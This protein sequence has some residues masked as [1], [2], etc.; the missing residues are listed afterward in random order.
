[1]IPGARELFVLDPSVAHLNHGSFGAVPTV[2]RDA[3]RRLLDEFDSNPMLMITGD[4]REREAASRA[5]LAHFLGAEEESCA[6][7]GN[8][9]L[10]ASIVL[11]SI[12]LREGDEIVITDHSYNA[13]TLAVQDLHRRR[14]VRVIVAPV[15]LGSSDAQTVDAI[16]AHVGERTRLVIV[17]EISSATAQRHP[18]AAIADAL[19]AR[20]V[21][22]LVDAAHAPGMLPK[23]LADIEVDFWMGN[24]HKWA[25]APTGTALLQ[26]SPRWRDRMAPLAVSHAHPAGFPTH[27]EQ[28]GTR[29]FTVWLAAPVGLSVFDRFGERTVQRHN[30]ELAAYGQRV[31]G[32]ALG[33]LPQQLPDPGPGVSMRIIP[34]PEGLAVDQEGIIA[35]RQRIADELRCEVTLNLFRGQTYLRVS[36]QIYNS[37]ADYDR[38]ADGLPALLRAAA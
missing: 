25:F 24:L 36:A 30:E 38:L 31:I 23:P 6:L 9:T 27:L 14:G 29:D 3:R 5:A 33:L 26:V 35:L 13:V 22:L 18:V 11:N 1:M 19:R 32:Q 7:I 15:E 17:D 28:Q 2:V 37:E 4:L 20:G 34:L 16:M 21:P 8:V 12:D 10:G